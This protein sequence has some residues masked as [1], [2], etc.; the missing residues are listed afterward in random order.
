MLESIN[1]TLQVPNAQ[2]VNGALQLRFINRCG[3][4]NFFGFSPVV[5]SQLITQ[6]SESASL[7]VSELVS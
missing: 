4:S 5:V 3:S 2:M 1:N 7:S 6:V